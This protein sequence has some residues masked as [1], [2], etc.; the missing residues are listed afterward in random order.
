MNTTQGLAKFYTT[1]EIWQQPGLWREVYQTVNAQRGKIKS[2]LTRAVASNK[3]RVIITGAGSSAFVGEIVAPYLNK[4]VP[5]RVEAIATTDIVASPHS[6]LSPNT[7]TLLISCARSGNSPESLATVRLAEQMVDELYQIIITCNRESDL[8]ASVTE[9]ANKLLLLMPPE[10]NDKGFA[11]TGS[12]TSLTLA[13]LLLFN[14]DRIET[15]EKEVDRIAALG[16]NALSNHAVSIEEVA[17]Q[18]IGRAVFLGSASL[19]GLARESALKLL[20]LTSGR[21]PT[22]AD[23]YLGF[24]HG[25]KSILDNTT[26]VFAYLSNDPYTR[27]YEIDLIR[28]MVQEDGNKKIIIISGQNYSDVAQYAD[29]Y[30]YLDNQDSANMEDVFWALPMILHAQMYALIKAWS[31]GIDPDNPCPDGRVNRVVQGVKIYPYED[32]SHHHDS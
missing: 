31:L 13:I 29:L 25:P 8:I 15:L 16:E 30:F 26:M 17:S 12:F 14:I 23:S 21:I 9:N 1:K 18:A 6:Y 11:M 22:S 24:R 7:P 20:E 28:E 4:T 19:Q 27:Q 5:Y 10:A 3:L 32:R 2:L